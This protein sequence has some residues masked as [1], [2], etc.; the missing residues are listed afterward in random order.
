MPGSRAKFVS[1]RQFIGALGTVALGLTA[2][3]CRVVQSNGG[4]ASTKC[5]GRKRTLRFA[6][7]CDI[8]VQP[9]RD[10]AEGLA[11]MLRHLQG[12][13]DGPEMIVTG[14]DNIMDCF[15]SG[16]GRTKTQ[17]DLF[18]TVLERECSLPIKH[19][20]G[21]H[22]VWG[23]DKE[24]SGTTGQEPLWGKKR[25]VHELEI[26]NR[27]YSF[28][29]GGWH[30]II[31][32]SVFQPDD[33]PTG[34]IGKLDD[35][36]F[37]WLE[38]DLENVNSPTPIVVVSHIPILSV[39][40]L[41]LEEPKEYMISVSGRLIHYD[42]PKLVRLFKQHPNIKLCLSGHRHLVDRV[43][44]CGT[45]YI[46]DGAVCGAWWKGDHYECDEGYGVIDL[47]DDGSFAHKYVTYDWQPRE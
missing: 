13:K 7:T 31:L 14:G 16:T 37:K 44:Y 8:H 28:D 3:S 39:A 30:F 27:Y 1:R 23:W 15:A 22:D 25:A 9:E 42:G 45:T 19:C 5:R 32:D 4:T 6:H 34:Y 46:C 17:W 11:A 47:Y 10:A 29:E 12:L 33:M 40:G 26:P 2:G 41:E 20:I 21:N 38:Q 43:E 18:K 36:Q 35:E 24:R